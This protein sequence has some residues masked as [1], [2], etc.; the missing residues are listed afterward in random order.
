MQT[1]YERDRA[2][3]TSFSSLSLEAR[4]WNFGM[5]TLACASEMNVLIKFTVNFFL[6]RALF[7]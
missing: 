2:L 4:G 5:H 3:V 7:L 1:L 6:A